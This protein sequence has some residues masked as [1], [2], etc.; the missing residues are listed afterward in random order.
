MVRNILSRWP[1]WPPPSAHHAGAADA[2]KAEV[3]H[4]WTSGGE[5]AAVKR[6]ADAYRAAG[7]VWQDTAVSIGEQARAVTINRIVGGNPPTR[8]STPPAS[9]RTWSSRAC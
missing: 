5:A 7:G 8:S 4:W 9:S 3:I 2:P 1:A 6:F